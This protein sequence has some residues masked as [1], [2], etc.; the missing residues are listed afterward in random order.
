MNRILNLCLG[1][2]F[3]L[4][5]FAQIPQDSLLLY[6][7]FNGNADDYS[8]NNFD[9]TVY[10]ANLVQDRFG[11]ANSAY[12]FDGNNDY[13]EF[14]N[15]SELKPELAI[16]VS[17][18]T[19]LESL[20]QLDN[21]FFST[22]PAPHYAG[23]TFNTSSTGTGGLN[24][25]YRD[26]LGG[27]NSIYRRSKHA[28]V[29]LTVGSWHHIVGIFRGPTDMDIYMDG[30]LYGGFYSGSGGSIGYANVAGAIGKASPNHFFWGTL[31]DFAYYNKS[32]TYCEVQELYNGGATETVDEIIVCDSY[33]WIDG[34]T[35]TTD[36]STATFILENSQGC[37]SVIR[38]DLDIVEINTQITQTGNQLEVSNLPGATYQWYMC[39]G[40]EYIPVSGG[41]SQTF[42]PSIEGL[43]SV[44][45]SY[46]GCEE[47]SP[48]FPYKVIGLEEINPLIF[49]LAYQ[50]GKGKIELKF[51]KQI[52]QARVKV[53]T[54]SGACVKEEVLNNVSYGYVG[55]ND[56]PSGV[57]FVSVVS[58]REQ[59]NK[60][61]V[62]Y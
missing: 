1:I 44:S 31:D 55:V 60:K 17:F 41:T 19:K 36:D 21:Q 40:D 20:D 58:E 5:T 23:C 24:I 49:D 22:S 13:I 3:S 27:T 54:V 32:L 14:P 2:C 25:D 37:D 59:A 26:N 50:S 34:N 62:L 45:I 56:L 53:Y 30:V 4:S 11:N 46:L 29:G 61:I 57:Y 33:E 9:G 51:K 12:Y 38:L 16:S 43:Y 15:V 48:C 28:E 7:P 52:N 35:Y 10:G 39:D 8:S 6:Y 42:T 47:S 18:W